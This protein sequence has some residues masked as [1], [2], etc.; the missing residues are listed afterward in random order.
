MFAQGRRD[1]T[2]GV[3][4]LRCDLSDAYSVARLRLRAA[5]NGSSSTPSSCNGLRMLLDIPVAMTVQSGWQ[6]CT[7][8]LN[9]YVGNG[10]SKK[11]TI[12]VSITHGEM[13]L[14]CATRAWATSKRFKQYRECRRDRTGVCTKKAEPTNLHRCPHASRRDFRRDRM[15]GGGEMHPSASKEPDWNV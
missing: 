11:A 13:A 5:A 9:C 8:L 12:I 4:S 2:T 1:C 15:C 14:L 3:R 6:I 7:C 10:S